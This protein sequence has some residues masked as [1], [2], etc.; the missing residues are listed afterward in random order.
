MKRY[1]TQFEPGDERIMLTYAIIMIVI[2]I[3]TLGIA[4]LMMI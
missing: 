3:T 4:T 1:N 2:G